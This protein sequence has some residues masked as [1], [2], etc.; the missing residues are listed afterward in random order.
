MKMNQQRNQNAQRPE[1]PG[2]LAVRADGTPHKPAPAAKQWFRVKAAADT[3]GRTEIEIYEQIGRD[4]WSH[5]GIAAK[6]FCQALAAIPR[7]TKILVRI[8]SAGGNVHDGLTIYNRLAER[9]QDLECRV[10]GV[11][12]S[13]ASVI[14][15]AGAKLSMPKNALLM[16]HDPWGMVQGNAAQLRSAAAVLDVHKESLMSVY[17]EHCTEPEATVRQWMA[18]EKWFTGEEALDCGFATEVTDETISLQAC[19]D[20]SLFRHPPKVLAGHNNKQTEDPMNRAAIIAALKK[21]GIKFSDDAPDAELQALL[22]AGVQPDPATPPA[23]P[24]AP[25]KAKAKVP[26]PAAAPVDPDADDDTPDPTPPPARHV[27]A[28][29]SVAAM[30]AQLDLVTAQLAGQRKQRIEARVAEFVAQD[31][32]PQPQAARWVALALNDESVLETLAALPSRPPGTPQLE[33]SITA[34]DPKA[35]EAGILAMREPLK[36]WLRGE[37]VA[38]KVLSHR[39]IQ[40]SV[41]LNRHRKRLDGI[42][43]TNTIDSDLK[44]AVILSD[45]MRAYKRRIVMLNAFS[46]RFTNVPLEGTN[47]VVVPYYELD[48]TTSKDFVAADGYVFDQDS[49]TGKRK[50]TV[51]KRKYKPMEFSSDEIRRQPYFNPSQNMVMKAEQLAL[52]VWLD[53][54]SLVKADPYGVEVLASEPASIDTDDII[55]LRKKAQQL[56]WPEVGRAAV[57]SEEHEAALLADDSLKHFLNAGSDQ[58]LREGASGRLLGFEMFYSPRIPHNS[59]ELAGFICLPQAVLVATAP[60]MPAPGVRQ[61]LI[62]YDLVVDPDT[63]IAFEWRYWGDAQKDKDRQVVEVNYGY[64]A[65]NSDALRRIVTGATPYFS[66]S[67]SGSSANSSSSS[68]S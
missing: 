66:S 41:E 14:A 65:G 21:A 58:A 34:E 42:L 28:P 33:L 68:T 11:A 32:L 44:R 45:F 54:L 53:V 43:A 26:Q 49:A 59:E 7:G 39:A 64:A 2:L 50:I 12:A 5:D 30:Q 18:D 63:G 29:A 17:M 10:D 51:N 60:I 46:T 25:R 23:A 8:N 47:E 9:R 16:I 48:S 19:A 22:E 27:A 20:M 67:S 62:S 52:D 61:Q 38:G 40:A 6:E 56:D 3:G 35:I 55:T 36:A 1:G 13:I 57:L 4:W 31:R 15:L 37:P 24:P